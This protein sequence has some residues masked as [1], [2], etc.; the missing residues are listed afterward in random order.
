MDIENLKG[1][2]LD[3]YVRQW[4]DIR[5]KKAQ[6]A[7][8]Y[9][10]AKGNGV[11]YAG[12]I[13]SN[14]IM[15]YE[16]MEDTEINGFGSVYIIAVD[17]G[18]IGNSDKDTVKEM[19]TSNANIQSI[20]NPKPI[21]GGTDE[22][23]DDI[24]L[25]MPAT[26]G[27]KAHYILWAL[28]CEGVGGAKATRDTIINNKVNLYICDDKGGTADSSI[29]KAVQE[30]IDPN[31]NGDGSGSAP[32]GAICEVFG[33]DVKNISVTGSIEPDNTIYGAVVKENIKTAINKYLSQ[34]NF[35]KTELSYAKL[36]NISLGCAGVNDITDFKI[37]N[38]YT[39]IT[40][41]ETEIFNLSDFGM[42]VI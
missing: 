20:T 42:E 30:H 8:G 25:Q 22:E 33:A 18:E 24:R 21:E 38:G 14:G 28:E 1:D 19:I 35:K 11:I 34:I 39:N 17:V 10:E 15:Q 26:S 3:A 13:V 37:N 12:T 27:N 41:E 16:V 23:T 32:I 31:K 2:E 5:R 4:T 29:I 36:L 7:S 40:C 9:L 6:K